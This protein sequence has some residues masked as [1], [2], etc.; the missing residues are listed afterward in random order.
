MVLWITI[1]FLFVCMH[2]YWVMPNTWS[3]KIFWAENGRKTVQAIVATAIVSALTAEAVSILPE[4]WGWF[5]A[6]VVDASKKAPRLM[7]FVIGFG[8]SYV[9]WKAAINSFWQ[10][11][12]FGASKIPVIGPHLVKPKNP[13]TEPDK[14]PI[15]G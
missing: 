6:R 12:R 15:A 7:G 11:L 3:L 10:L 14:D 8:C 5:T 4:S 1:G 13:E 2:R 9:D